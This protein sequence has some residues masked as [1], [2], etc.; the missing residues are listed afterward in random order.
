[1]WK[2]PVKRNRLAVSPVIATI[3]MV[4]VTVVLAAVLL[5]LVQSIGEDS[6]PIVAEFEHETGYSPAAFP[7]PPF[8]TY[9]IYLDVKFI[10]Q[11]VP[12]DQIVVQYS[13]IDD[14]DETVTGMFEGTA[15]YM[16]TWEGDGIVRT[17]TSA[18]MMMIG[19]NHVDNSDFRI[20]IIHGPSGALLGTIAISDEEWTAD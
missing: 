6:V 18:T 7:V 9:Y 14:F 2:E 17:G 13:Y 5:V 8:P 11:G 16:I 4:A 20:T 10:S 1:M 19:W 12:S 15:P 3:L